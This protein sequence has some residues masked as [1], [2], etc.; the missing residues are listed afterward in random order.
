MNA[1]PGYGFEILKIRI[2]LVTSNVTKLVK[3]ISLVFSRAYF[4]A[5][6][7]KTWLKTAIWAHFPNIPGLL[8]KE[9][10]TTVQKKF[11]FGIHMKLFSNFSCLPMNMLLKNARKY[12]HE[13]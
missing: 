13:I 12:H 11:F 9:K 4:I 5:L 1:F 6:E 7:S 8:C 3:I 10:K 2:V